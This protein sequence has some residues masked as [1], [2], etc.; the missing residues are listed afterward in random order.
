MPT[1]QGYCEDLNPTISAKILTHSNA[2]RYYSVLNASI[3][4][5]VAAVHYYSH[6]TRSSWGWV[7]KGIE[8]QGSVSCN[9]W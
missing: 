8:C 3:K 2:I 4:Y 5:P 6:Y 7:T 1:L 9:T